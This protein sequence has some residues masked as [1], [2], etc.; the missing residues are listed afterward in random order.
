[1]K[2]TTKVRIIAR[3]IAKKAWNHFFTKLRAIWIFGAGVILSLIV[4]YF[5]QTIH[6]GSWNSNLYLRMAGFVLQLF[7]ISVVFRDTY[8]VL[9]ELEK[10]SKCFKDNLNTLKN[11]IINWFKTILDIFKPVKHEALIEVG[12]SS[13][14]DIKRINTL[15]CLGKNSDDLKIRI[16]LL[17]KRL[18]KFEIQTHNDIDS[19]KNGLGGLEN[20]V[21][22]EREKQK[23]NLVKVH[24]L[25][26]KISTDGLVLEAVALFW[27]LIGLI[28]TIFP[29][30]IAVIYYGR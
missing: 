22:D 19:L 25:I 12:L 5:L 2:V 13:K 18:L 21:V 6:P 26:E 9:Q 16:E 30:E 3:T 29:N 28:L 1:M 23:E 10:I 7:F 11:I 17:E 4:P 15:P 24:N 20:K 27:L 8:I 14:A